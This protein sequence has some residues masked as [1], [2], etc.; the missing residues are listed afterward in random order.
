MS[1]M[2]EGFEKLGEKDLANLL[3][4]LSAKGKYFP[5]PLTKAA[6]VVSTR[7]GMFQGDDLDYE[8][9]VFTAW[10][11][12]VAD[13]IPFQIIDPLGDR[14]PNAI[15][16]YGPRTAVVKQYPRTVSV[17]CNAKAKAIHLLSGVSGWGFPYDRQPTVSLIVR[18]HY[19][20]G[21]SEDHPLVNGKHFAD[22]AGAANVPESKLAFRLRGQQIR[23]VV[24]TPKRDALIERVEFVK[25]DDATAPVIMA[26]TVEGP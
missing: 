2:P 11:Q 25:G 1:L 20:D 3:G 15:V 16:L 19:A 22:F 14:V 18:L 17:P 24:V 7:G 21:P 26:A 8:K 13:G 9:L 23:H 12:Q 4:F 10:G 5:L 6:N